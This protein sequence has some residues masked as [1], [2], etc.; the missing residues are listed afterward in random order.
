MNTQNSSHSGIVD[1][2]GWDL[3][4]ERDLWP[5]IQ[6]HIRFRKPEPPKKWFM[7]I[8][9]AACLMLA[10]GAFTLSFMSYQQSSQARDL[11]AQYVEF[12]KSQ[13]ALME[14]HHNLVRMQFV[15]LLNSDTLNLQTRNELQQVLVVF[16]QAGSELKNAMLEQ[17]TNT[18]YATQ[19]ADTYKQELTLLNS[20]TTNY[21]NNVDI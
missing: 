14:Q 17:P 3:A 6:A 15:A 8:A 7:P 4:P 16:D 10:F 2:L 20:I 1:E 12:Q 18:R 11:Q 13:I 19:L 9:V 5:D 21:A